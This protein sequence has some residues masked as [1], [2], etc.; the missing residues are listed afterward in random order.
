MNGGQPVRN[1]KRW[2]VVSDM[3]GCLAYDTRKVGLFSILFEEW[4]LLSNR[5]LRNWLGSLMW[6]AVL[7]RA[8]FVKNSDLLPSIEEAQRFCG[9][10]EGKGYFDKESVLSHIVGYAEH[11][12][13]ISMTAEEMAFPRVGIKQHGHGF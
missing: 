13:I 7:E 6:L 2:M 10:T 5:K 1:H 11:G 8:F 4:T 12:D 3:D 9:E